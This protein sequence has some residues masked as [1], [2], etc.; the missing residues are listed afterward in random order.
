MINVYVIWSNEHRSWWGPDKCGYRTKLENAGRYSRD[1]ALDICI[2]A[3][4]GRQYNHNLTEV[5]VLLKDA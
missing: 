1:D 2:D 3:R 4:G 5:P